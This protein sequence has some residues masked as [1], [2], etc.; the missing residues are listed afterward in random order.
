M[1]T[2]MAGTFKNSNV[3]VH[4]NLLSATNKIYV[5]V[6]CLNTQIETMNLRKY[7]YKNKMNLYI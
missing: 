3:A 6:Q 2:H 4:Q 7:F 1:F 5:S